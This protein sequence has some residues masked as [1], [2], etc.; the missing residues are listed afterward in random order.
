[1]RARHGATAS[2]VITADI[3]QRRVTFCNISTVLLFEDFA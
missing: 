3:L 2:Q 1:M